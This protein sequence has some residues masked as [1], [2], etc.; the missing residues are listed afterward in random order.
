MYN[1]ELMKKA[2]RAFDWSA[3]MAL[4]PE[5][6]VD[7]L[8]ELLSDVSRGGCLIRLHTISTQDEKLRAQLIEELRQLCSKIGGAD[9]SGYFEYLLN[10]IEIVELALAE[11]DTTLDDDDFSS[12]SPELQVW[13]VISWT[14]REMLDV[15]SSW[16]GE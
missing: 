15:Q 7:S 1:E 11:I 12:L 5:Q 13:S 16:N 6:T 8:R 14:A 10:Q 9:G 4:L 3:V 2:L